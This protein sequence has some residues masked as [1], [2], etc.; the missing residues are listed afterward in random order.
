VLYFY[1]SKE[2]DVSVHVRFANGVITEWYPRASRVEPARALYDRTLTNAHVDG[3]IAWDA[4][5]IAP[6]LAM[7]FPQDARPNHYYAARQT[8]STPLKVKTPAGEQREKFLFY[9]GVSVFP[10]PLAANA[11]ATNVRVVNRGKEQ[12]ANII[13]FE[14]RGEKLGYRIAGAFQEDTALSA[15]ELNGTVNDLARELEGILVAQGLYYN[16]ARAMVET[17]RDSWFEEGSRLLYIVPENFVNSVVPLTISPAPTQTVRVFVGR[18]ELVTPAT[19]HA[20]QQALASHDTAALAKYGRF[21][22][23]ILQTMMKNERDA[24]RAQIL[25]LGLESAYGQMLRSASQTTNLGQEPDRPRGLS[26]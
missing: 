19:Q 25:R 2:Q 12:I 22:E 26:H 11:D 15:P 17:W 3:S 14:R 24:T 23:P 21:L 4:V 5:T 16:E 20:I 1:S 8:T 18:L 10:P 13:L 7:D 9:R 6:G